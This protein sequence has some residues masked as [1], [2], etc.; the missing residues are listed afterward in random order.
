MRGFRSL[1]LLPLFVGFCCPPSTYAHHGSAA[2][3]TK[4]TVILT[5]AVT[6]LQL[7]NPH[8]TIALDSKDDKGNVSHWV[9]EFGVLR[10]LVEQG[11]T[12]T[13]LKPGD[14]IKVSIHAKSDGDHSG[15]LVGDITYADGKPIYL[16][17]PNGQQSYHRPMHW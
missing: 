8:S 12:N 1:F 4:N 6:M 7:A 14:Q 2:Y 10:D 15:L 11:W 3:D 16:K 17:P 9:V 5:G 13:T